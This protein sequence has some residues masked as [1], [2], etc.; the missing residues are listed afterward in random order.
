M[1]VQ[2]LK[3]RKEL[4]EEE[5]I[6]LRNQAKDSTA[7]D[8]PSKT[9]PTKA[10]K[11]GKIGAPKSQKRRDYLESIRKSKRKARTK[12]V[13]EKIEEDI[14]LVEEA[15]IVIED[16][17]QEVEKPEPAAIKEKIKEP[18]PVVE[19]DYVDYPY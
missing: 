2:R 18:G 5:H 17:K 11:W 8:M 7:G 14:E 6:L 12:M 1:A 15:A 16:D 4:S 13:K 3:Y 9:S 19:K 10:V